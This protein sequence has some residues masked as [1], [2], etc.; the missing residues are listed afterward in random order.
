MTEPPCCG[1]PPSH[2]VITPPDHGA[3]A[4]NVVSLPEAPT[5]A[6]VV[7]QHVWEAL[8][9]WLLGGGRLE[10][11]PDA[12]WIDAQHARERRVSH[13]PATELRGHLRPERGAGRVEH[14]QGV[15]DVHAHAFG[16]ELAQDL[17]G[18]G[19]GDT[20]SFVAR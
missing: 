7:E 6:A 15:H 4:P 20:R 16:V 9:E 18:D 1:S 19:H 13:R 17:L 8:S 2:V 5:E 10:G 11:D 14:V 3:V 12:R